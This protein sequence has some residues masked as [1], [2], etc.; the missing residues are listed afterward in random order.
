MYENVLHPA[1]V[2]TSVN[3]SAGVLNH[4]LQQNQ[5]LLLKPPHNMFSLLTNQDLHTT[6]QKRQLLLRIWTAEYIV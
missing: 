3:T 4:G 5:L 2:M 1:E 6:R